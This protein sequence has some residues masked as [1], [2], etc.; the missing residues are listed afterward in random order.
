[1]S[2]SLSSRDIKIPFISRVCFFDEIFSFFDLASDFFSKWN[3]LKNWFYVLILRHWFIYIF[4]IKNY[5]NY[6]FNTK[7]QFDNNFY[8]N[9][10]ICFFYKNLIALLVAKP[11]SRKDD[12]FTWNTGGCSRSSRSFT[13]LI[14]DCSDRDGEVWQYFQQYMWIQAVYLHFLYRKKFFQ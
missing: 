8:F 10:F 14:Y 5:K 2:A 7:I 9:E 4:D 3:F 6:F 12:S 11:P 13:C 1:M